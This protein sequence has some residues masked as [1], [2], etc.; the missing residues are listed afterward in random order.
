MRKNKSKMTPFDTVTL[1]LALFCSLNYFMFLCKLVFFPEKFSTV[2][3]TFTVFLGATLPLILHRPLK[4]QLKKTYP[5]FKGLFALCLAIYFVT[6]SGLFGYLLVME[7]SETPPK[8]LPENTVLIVFGARVKGTEEHSYPGKALRLRLDAAYEVLKEADGT[9]CIVSGGQGLDEPDFE[10]KVMKEY[11]IS[12]GIE[13]SRITAETASEDTRENIRYSME[14]I[15]EKYKGY[16]V[17]CVSSN[18]HIPRIKLLCDEAGLNCEYFYF[19]PSADPLTYYTSIVR[20]YMTLGRQ[21]L[22]RAVG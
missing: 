12:K 14:I 7:N 21:L 4:R 17:A 9:V 2:A 22:S 18:Y 13:E 5:F 19:A 8:E 11:L 10:G 3:I 6:F 1:I 20:E 15:E 16:H